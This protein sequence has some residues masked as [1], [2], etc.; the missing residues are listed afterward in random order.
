MMS[1]G[2]QEF[3]EDDLYTWNNLINGVHA[4][5]GKG[6]SRGFV[7]P[8]CLC[9]LLRSPNTM[10]CPPHTHAMRHIGAV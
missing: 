8:C 5:G 2:D 10:L 3:D 7:D 4:L 9:I 1:M 6:V